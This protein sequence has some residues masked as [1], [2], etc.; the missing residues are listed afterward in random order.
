[1]H[2]IQSYKEILS[3]LVGFFLSVVVVARLTEML[4]F[5]L[6]GQLPLA[7]LLFQT[8]CGAPLKEN[9]NFIKNR[10]EYP[11]TRLHFCFI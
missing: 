6:K 8:P 9:K 3:R 4:C 2:S 10:A 7:S 5:S 1:M 11:P